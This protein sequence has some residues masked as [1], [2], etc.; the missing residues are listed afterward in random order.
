MGKKMGFQRTDWYPSQLHCHRD[1][2]ASTNTLR[3]VELFSIIICLEK[4]DK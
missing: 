4:H 3:K 2:T 1:V